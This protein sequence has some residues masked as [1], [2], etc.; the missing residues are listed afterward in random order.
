MEKKNLCFTFP[1]G[2]VLLQLLAM[3]PSMTFI[4]LVRVV[5]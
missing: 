5:T 1:D 2:Q 4:A 3:A